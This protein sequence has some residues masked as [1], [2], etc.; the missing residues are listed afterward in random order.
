MAATAPMGPPGEGRV[1]REGELRCG[2]GK[3]RVKNR[4]FFYLCQPDT[5]LKAK[6]KI[7]I[8]NVLNS[9]CV[10]NLI[11]PKNYFSY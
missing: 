2:Y 9:R 10:R 6:K 8:F 1:W 11:L 5:A 7:K 3:E 4:A